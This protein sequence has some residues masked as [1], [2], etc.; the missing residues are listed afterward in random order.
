[1]SHLVV[2]VVILVV[3]VISIVLISLSSSSWFPSQNQLEAHTS[4]AIVLNCMDFRLIDDLS[5]FLD[6]DG[7]NNN[8]DEVILA[9]ASL[10]LMQNT[11]PEWRPTAIA[12]IDLARKLHHIHEIILVDHMDCG[13]YKLLYNQSHFTADEEY[14]LHAQNL[15]AAAIELQTRYP[16]LKIRKLLMNL[17]GT[18]RV[19]S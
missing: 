17:D 2:P 15:N 14:A 16:E 8:F 11:Y 1:M 5:R 7:Y 18:V 6:A 12:H 10:G 9:G 13:A 3:V 4:R 19:I